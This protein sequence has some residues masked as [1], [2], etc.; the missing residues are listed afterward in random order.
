MMAAA[1]CA[2]SVAGY[3]QGA[4]R[5]LPHLIV[6]KTKKD[7][8]QYVPVQLSADK[9]TVVSY[10]DTADVKTGSG[11]PLPVILHKG[12]LLD[13]RGVDTN[14]AFIKITYEAYAA[15]KTAPDAAALYGLITDKEPLTQL[16]DCG[17][18]N[19][20]NVSVKQLNQLIDRK[21]LRKKCRVVR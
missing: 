16:C 3:A 13:K 18:R 20:A 11:Y 21:L 5:A 14:T 10:P 17:I 1:L 7:Y 8:R 19:N 15:L 4:K 2:V 9:K 6:Y 12:Y